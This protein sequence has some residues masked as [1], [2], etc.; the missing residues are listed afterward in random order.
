MFIQNEIEGSLDDL[1]SAVIFCPLCK[2]KCAMDHGQTSGLVTTPKGLFLI[3][4]SCVSA[5]NERATLL[6][7]L[8]V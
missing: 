1:D 3:H 7:D 5:W 2:Q 8:G 4:K 6:R